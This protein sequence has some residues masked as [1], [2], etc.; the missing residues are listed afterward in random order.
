MVKLGPEY[1][2]EVQ[3]EVHILEHIHH[4]VLHEGCEVVEQ[5]LRKPLQAEDTLHPVMEAVDGAAEG[6]NVTC[7]VEQVEQDMTQS[8]MA[9]VES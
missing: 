3:L 6:C 4:T 2:V 8:Q 5:E 1:K 7:L 9:E